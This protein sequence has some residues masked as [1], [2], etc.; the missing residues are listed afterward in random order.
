MNIKMYNWISALMTQMLL[1][2]GPLRAILTPQE[3]EIRR[4]TVGSQPWANSS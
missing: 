1:N 3:A 2:T 4:I